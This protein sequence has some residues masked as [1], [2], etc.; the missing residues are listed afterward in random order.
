ALEM[1]AVT[2]GAM[3][4]GGMYDQVGGGFARYSVDAEWVV[5]HFEKML[6]D[7]ALLLRAYLHWWRS[8]REV[9]AERVARET[10]Q[11]LMAELRTPEGGFAS[12]LDA[13]SE[14]R[15]GAY[16]VWTPGQLEEALG[17]E[18]APWV[19][20]LCRVTSEGTFED[21]ASVLQ[22]RNDPDDP[23]RWLRCRSELA[24]AR[25]SRPRPARDDKVVAAWNG[26][27]IAALAEAGA[28][29]DMPGWIAAAEQCADLLLTHHW[30]PATRHLARVSLARGVNHEATGVLEDYA[31]VAEGLFALYQVTGRERWHASAQEL[32]SAILER[33]P[34]GLGGFFD[35]AVD[36]PRLVRR[37]QDPG[38]GVTPSGSSAAASALLTGAALSGS[39]DRRVA[40]EHA[41]D[42]LLPTARMSPRFSG[43]AWAAIT[44]ALAG[45]MQVG[46]VLPRSATDASDGPNRAD[47]GRRAP[48]PAELRFAPHALDPLHLTSLRSTSPG[49]VVAVAREGTSAVGLLRD[50]PA[51]GGL[52][53]AYPCRGFVCDLPVTDAGALRLSLGDRD[54][55]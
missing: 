52:P 46:V 3:A 39:V 26:L 18:D 25:A 38:D 49:L 19:A 7:N 23:V 33:F 16:Y 37:P 22:L 47:R 30:V 55:P 9:L 51:I 45:P 4:R 13:D 28:L 35:T 24:Q 54:P 53:T 5:P 2:M 43:W 36:A 34:D 6:Y 11:F 42:A 44:A 20:R 21:G 15:E 40:A 1:A 32:L 12:S 41:L 8:T 17:P 48:D 10:A 27:A 31:D 50:R 29:L 14:G